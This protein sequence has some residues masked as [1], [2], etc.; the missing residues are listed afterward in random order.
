VDP[1]PDGPVT[2]EPTVWRRRITALLIDMGLVTSLGDL[3]SNNIVDPSGAPWIALIPGFAWL[4]YRFVVESATRGISLG[5]A[6]A[7]IS[8]ARQSGGP[9]TPKQTLARS[10]FLALLLGVNVHGFLSGFEGTWLPSSWGDIELGVTFGYLAACAWPA[11][12]SQQ[13]LLPHDRWT[14]TRVAYA[15]AQAQ[16]AVEAAVV[17][18]A[19][20]IWAGALLGAL[21]GMAL[22]TGS[23]KDRAFGTSSSQQPSWDTSLS[24]SI[25]RMTHVRNEVSVI[26]GRE[27]ST[28]KGT[29]RTAAVEVEIPWGAGDDSTMNAILGILADSVRADPTRF[30][31]LELRVKASH[32]GL[33]QMNKGLKLTAIPDTTRSRWVR[34]D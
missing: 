15:D 22:A 20:W 1:A 7:G 14:R 18:P 2:W 29:L 23:L 8:V 12:R 5:K 28:S 25:A 3:V 30:D 9:P 16:A 10:A 4:A 6:I 32:S 34:K 19:R 21:V 33:F 11:L 26:T 13:A 24:R 17:K 27:W 31:R